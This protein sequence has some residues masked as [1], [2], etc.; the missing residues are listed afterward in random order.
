MSADELAENER[1]WREENDEKFKVK[2]TTSASEMRSAGI[3]SANIQQDLAA[4]EPETTEPVEPAAAGT[5]TPG[6]TPTT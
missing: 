2:P 6:E 3:T 1:L 4:Q 5:A